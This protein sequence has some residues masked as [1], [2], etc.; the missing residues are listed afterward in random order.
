MNPM[1]E[2]DRVRLVENYEPPE[3]RHGFVEK[4]LEDGSFGVRYDDGK[5][6]PY[7]PG[8]K[9]LFTPMTPR[10]SRPER[11][12]LFN[13]VV[14][15]GAAGGAVSPQELTQLID[16][17]LD[18]RVRQLLAKVEKAREPFLTGAYGLESVGWLGAI[19]VI[20]QDLGEC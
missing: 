11:Q 2:G 1:N 13:A 15:P 12:A 6:V 9:H 5:L 18:E 10:P 16:R 8:D 3:R 7:A 14:A 19:E 4:V 17:A 20:R